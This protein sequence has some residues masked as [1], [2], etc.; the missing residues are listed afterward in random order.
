MF[1]DLVTRPKFPHYRETRATIPLSH[2]VAAVVSQA[3]A[4]T[5][6][7]L[8]VK[9]AY[10]SPKTD[11]TRRISQKKLAS[12]AYGAI[13]GIAQNSISNRALLRH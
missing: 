8:S 1:T 5:P 11:L 7:L 3:I 12:E 6:P 9:M 10:R 2:C 4:A 13:G